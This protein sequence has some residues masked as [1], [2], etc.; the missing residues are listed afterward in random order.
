[1]RA[2]AGWRNPR[3]LRR[4]A[5]EQGEPG[6]LFLGM[7]QRGVSPASVPHRLGAPDAERS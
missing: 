5:A 1:M 2:D 6:S 7:T 3:R 4:S